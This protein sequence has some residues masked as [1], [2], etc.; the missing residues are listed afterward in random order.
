MSS[1]AFHETGVLGAYRVVPEKI[2]DERGVFARTF[3]RQTFID[4]GL[5]LPSEQCS[6]SFNEHA[7]TLRGMHYQA[8]PF[9]EV[10]LVRCT[11]GRIFDV[12]L[13]LRP[14][15]P[16][17]L[18]WAGVELSAESHEALYVPS[19]CAHGFLTLEPHSEVFYQISPS[20]EAG[21]GRGVRFDDP[22]FGIAWPGQ[23]KVVSERDRAFADFAGISR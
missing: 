20:F 10:K 16:T 3:C 14:D 23:V 12:A 21:A 22:A 7:R 9:E 2:H 17:Y 18:R 5:A 19:G 15:S 1:P 13:D 4:A 6:I 8:A 11:R